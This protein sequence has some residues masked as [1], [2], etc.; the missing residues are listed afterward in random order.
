MKGTNPESELV[1]AL[2]NGAIDTATEM[3]KS[4][5]DARTTADRARLHG[6]ASTTP[7]PRVSLA[8]VGELAFQIG[9]LQAEFL[10]RLVGIQQQHATRMHQRLASAIGL[11]TS[12]EHPVAVLRL[13]G[14][15]DHV[16][17]RFRVKN[18]LTRDGTLVG[19]LAGGA[20]TGPDRVAVPASC[21]LVSSTLDDESWKLKREQ[22]AMV[23]LEMKAGGLT[24]GVAYRGIYTVA[25]DNEPVLRLELDIMSGGTPQGAP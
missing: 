4:L 20:V 16:R 9:Q 10:G 11:P 12:A 14:E 2:R 13:R 17:G 21:R 15:G 19:A 25:V 24:R 22:V 6:L 3:L 23:E 8:G 18:S 5:H 1:E 7:M